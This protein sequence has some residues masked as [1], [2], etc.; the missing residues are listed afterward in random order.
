M[1]DLAATVVRT[2][3]LTARTSLRAIVARRPER[4]LLPLIV[5]AA[6]LLWDLL[7]LAGGVNPFLLPRP[8]AVFHALWA[9]FAS[10][11]FSYHVMVTGYEALTGFVIAAGAGIAIGAAVALSPAV[12]HVAYPYLVGV[13]TLPK[14][15]LA[16]LFVIWFGYDE[17]SKIAV[18]AIIS[19]FPVLANVVAGLRDC[20]EGKLDV[21][22]SLSASRG[23]ILWYVRLPNALPF[24]FNGLSIAM[25]FA[26]TGAI[27]GEFV[28]ASAGMGYVMVR[29][30]SQMDIPMGFAGMIVLAVL[31]ATLFGVIRVLRRRLV[32]WGQERQVDSL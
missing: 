27:V 4:F 24:V 22:R 9:G 31:G 17:P 6:L 3:D 18:A 13:Q 30:N 11:E 14:V 16:P 15:A 32:Y 21:M 12:A 25:V 19:F 10:G 5:L 20:D 7:V 8:W 2:P 29:A 26:L 23:Q 1:V 28:N